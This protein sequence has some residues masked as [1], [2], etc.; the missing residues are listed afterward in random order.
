MKVIVQ[1]KPQE[2]VLAPVRPGAKPEE[3]RTSMI[4]KSECCVDHLC[5]CSCAC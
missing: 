2:K 1:P 3:V 4:E 5:G